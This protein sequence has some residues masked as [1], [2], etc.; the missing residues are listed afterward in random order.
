MTQAINIFNNDFYQLILFVTLI[1]A[2]SSLVQYFLL[3]SFIGR[4]Y[5]LFVAPGVVVH[6]FSHALFCLLTGAK[7]Q[8]IELFKKEGGQVAYTKSKIPV[9]SDFLISMA[10]LLIGLVIIYFLSHWLGIADKKT[11]LSFNYHSFSNW[12]IFYLIVSIAVTM[13]PSKQDLKN[14]LFTIVGIGLMVWLL[15]RFTNFKEYITTVQFDNMVTALGSV[16]FVLFVVTIFS[17]L[18]YLLSKSSRLR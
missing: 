9:I 18:V 3:N 7:I 10:P 17:L 2:A 5:R 8:S 1:L 15:Y 12:I 6:E 16:A 13:T 14:I 11:V 4:R